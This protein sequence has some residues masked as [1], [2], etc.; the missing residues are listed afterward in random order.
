LERNRISRIEGLENCR[1]L[2]ELVL[3]EQNHKYTGFSFDENSLAAISRS[4]A[5]LDL[6]FCRVG[7][8]RQLGMLEN[9]TKLKLSDN[10]I[11]NLDEEVICMLNTMQ[12]LEELDLR[13]NE[14]AKLSV[15]YRDTVIVT[16]N[17]LTSLDGKE[18]VET[19][20]KYIANLVKQRTRNKRN[21]EVMRSASNS[22]FAVNLNLNDPL[23]R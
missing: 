10:N 11:S 5:V 12:R 1:K 4:L 13:R 15:K 22:N 17:S 16:C 3:N 8:V 7:S 23:A 14:V 6:S 2:K 19:Q 9:L 18:V 21:S 20:R